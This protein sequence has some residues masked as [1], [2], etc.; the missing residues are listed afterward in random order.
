M[1]T[2]ALPRRK[3][4]LIVT[5]SLEGRTLF[6]WSAYASLIKQD[7]AASTYASV[8]GAGQTVAI[9]DTGID[10]T[11]ASLGGGFGAGK[12]VIGGYDF[13]DNDADPKDTAGH[14]TNV[15][16][17]IAANRFTSGGVTY[18]G[19]APSAKLVGLRVSATGS[20]ISD[21]NI[22]RA[23]KWVIAN[24]K[25]YGISVVNL[26]LGAGNYT[27]FQS[28]ASYSA[29]FA[30]LAGLGIVVVAASGNSG[31]SF[32]AGIAYPA[33]DSN[34][35]S[36]GSINSSGAISS[37][38][39]RSSLL[40]ILAPGENVTTTKMGGGYETVSGTSF[41]SPLIAGM[42]ALLKQV[43]GTF[44]ERDVQS[45]LR[46]S[47]VTTYD[48]STGRDYARVNMTAALGYAKSLV[49][50]TAVATLPAA[51]SSQIDLEYDQTGTAY[52]AW[53]DGAAKKVK[54]STR[55][56]GTSKWSAPTTIDA[57]SA[58]LGSYLSLAFDQSGKPAVAYYD[59]TNGDL[60][61]ARYSGTAWSAAKIDTA[62]N[63]G[64]Y[65]SL[66]FD[67]ADE[68]LIAYKDAT[69]L[70]LKF[71]AWNRDTN[72]WS[73]STL[74]STGDVGDWADL[75]IGQ[76][77]GTDVVAIAYADKTNGDLKYTRYSLAIAS[78]WQTYVVD[79]LSGVAHIN[80]SLLNGRAAI[81]YQDTT[82]QDLKYA[83]RNSTWFTET[84]ASTGNVGAASQVYYDRSGNLK[85]AYR[86]TTRNGVYVATRS[87][88]GAWTIDAAP[89]ASGGAVLSV[90]LNSIAGGSG[91]LL[92]DSAGAVKLIAVVA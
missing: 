3:M 16:G 36:A 91:L 58:D 42:A 66:A 59:K 23:L 18:Q 4:R 7:A 65:A 35:L 90:S 68:P 43:G 56:N 80:L 1:S 57:A 30:T 53:Y 14:G 13:V 86:D 75:A 69:N 47:S 45:I 26:S 81:S 33:A 74:D 8:T 83:Y 48:S 67:S 20:S 62:G 92:T 41:S 60:K 22:D 12:K 54:L 84:V 17:M 32:G 46:Y 44:T 40:N 89:I 71:A 49:A 55:V 10:Y 87:S 39:Q 9:I 5:D 6:A 72:A 21:T 78:T 27:S 73:L 64:Q 2:K 79:N 61:L 37:F 24:Y 28:N 50:S 88:T 31:T 82:K 25:T 85:I 34:V 52:A 70:D 51:N 38:T 19:I 63:V 15:A 29:D 76:S 11:N 77:N